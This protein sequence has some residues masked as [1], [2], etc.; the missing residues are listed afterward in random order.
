PHRSA[1]SRKRAPAASTSSTD[2]CS[3][4]PCTTMASWP[5]SFPA[6]ANWL[7][8]SASFS[9]PV[10]GDLATTANL[11]LVVS[12]VPT[13]GDNTK[14]SGPAAGGGEPVHQ[15]GAG[16]AAA[17]VGAEQFVGQRQRVRGA[18]AR[19]HDQRP[20]EVPARR[21]QDQPPAVIGSAAAVI[22]I[23]R[24]RPRTGKT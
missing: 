1:A 18:R 24:P 23:S 11:A 2:G 15:P 22:A 12:G 3:Q 14:A 8:E 9:M 4:A 20:A 21:H 13:S 16:P 5:V 17:D 7:E 19:A 6:I 10:S